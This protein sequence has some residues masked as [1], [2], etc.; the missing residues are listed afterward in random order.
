V[1][2]CSRLQKLL[3][4]GP[5]KTLGSIK[6][7]DGSG[8]FTED[9]EETLS[10]L[11]KT[12]F[13]GSNS[14]ASIEEDLSAVIVED[15]PIANKVVTE[16]RIKW[17]VNSF[18]PYK[19]PGVDGIYP[20]LLQ[21]GLD[22]LSPCLVKL[23]KASINSGHIP[24]AWRGV[25][26]TFIPK[27]GKTDYT[28]PRA[29]RP[30]SLMSFILKGLERLVDRYIR[31]DALVSNPLHQ[32]QFAYQAG[33]STEAALHCLV[34]KVEKTLDQQEF[35][36]AV[37]ID[38]EG[39][40]DNTPFSVI[41][42][43]AERHGIHPSLT[44]WMFNMLKTR[45]VTATLFDVDVTVTTSRGCPQGGCLSCLMWSL[46]VNSLLDE[47][48][49]MGGVWAE[50][51]A[52]DVVIYVTGKFA[53]I[54]RGIA[55][56]AL[57]TTEKW[58]GS[59]GLSI[60]PNKTTVVPFTRL[61]KNTQIKELQLFGS[62]VTYEKQVRYLGVTL[63]STLTWNAHLQTIVDKTNKAYW[64]CRRMV[65]SSW[66]LKPK[67]VAWLYTQVI[68]PRICYGALVWS[69]KA[70]QQTSMARLNGLQRMA[71]IAVTGA[72]RTTP[73]P[74][75]DVI[76]DWVPLHLKI[77]EA[78][79]LGA[80]RLV[81]CGLWVDHSK[82]SG[83]TVIN[84]KLQTYKEYWRLSDKVLPK[85]VFDRNFHVIIDERSAIDLETYNSREN[86]ITC[87]TDG[88]KS[89]VGTGLGVYNSGLDI[90]ISANVGP[91][92]TVFQTEIKAI[93]ICAKELIAR[94]TQ[95]ECIL[96]FSDSQSALR[97]LKQNKIC[98]RT[99]WDCLQALQSLGETNG[100]TL[101]WVPGH[102]GIEG[103]EHADELA[104]E[105][106]LLPVPGEPLPVSQCLVRRKI[107]EDSRRLSQKFWLESKGQKQAKA[108]LGGYN[109]KRTSSLLKLER[110]EVCSV[111]RYLTGHCCLRRHLM[112][113]KMS[114]TSICR[115]CEMAEETSEHILCDCP[116]LM[117]R[118]NRIW[119]SRLISVQNL[120]KDLLHIVRFLKLIKII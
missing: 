73:G 42:E 112:R 52:D 81:S 118:R 102:C 59:T 15:S 93:E 61:K 27:A 67:M 4:S 80:L 19:S 44:G 48:N 63:D 58:C 108:L 12:H 23:F 55:Q 41:I 91:N 82:V 22:V 86:T 78:A 66:G 69:H 35:G 39:A 79:L 53:E 105:G 83:H 57:K 9:A 38:I 111:T 8:T 17:A 54:V 116:A 114:T 24:A 117:L 43:S 89:E 20:F 26:A 65:G 88:S 37:F 31:E 29:S 84:K 77:E 76:L 100:V 18:G 62:S 110:N 103:N 85:F 49:A 101:R 97:A 32:Y 95:G 40:F 21:E 94:D 70:K 120:Q 6:K 56:S 13:P 30:I 50:G 60:N 25:R 98:S 96:M 87:F 45:E 113:M 75:L 2:E 11:L 33:K 92:A 10:V 106:L 109:E 5:T 99:V 34:N 68:L 14:F 90:A 64:A 119:G 16:E 71:A 74:A 51:Y 28:D 107:R 3:S 104:K 72:M 115:F 36:L 7:T 46:V 1:G 47:L